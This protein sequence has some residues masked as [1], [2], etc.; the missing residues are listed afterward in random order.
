VSAFIV[1]LQAAV[2]LHPPDQAPKVAFNAG[3]AV[4]VTA[5]PDEKL[6]VQVDPQLMPEGLLVMVPA[7]EVATVSWK[8]DGGGALTTIE[9]L[10][11]T[12]ND[13]TPRLQLMMRSFRIQDTCASARF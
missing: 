3:A 12:S 6:A 11:P 1:T 7:P 13:S 9:P 10:Q 2:P 8:V 4:R 5:V